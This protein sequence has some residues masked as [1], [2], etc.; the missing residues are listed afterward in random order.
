MIDVCFWC[1]RAKSGDDG[2]PVYNNYDFCERCEVETKKGIVVIQVTEIEN[3]NPQIDNGIYPTGRWIV[4]SV[5]NIKTSLDGYPNLDKVLD[6]GM[7]YVNINDWK[8]LGLPE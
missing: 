4:A 8:K 5:E 3:G 1:K 6:T 7:M 2:E